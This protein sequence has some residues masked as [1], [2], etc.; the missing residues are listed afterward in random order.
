MHG[1]DQEG[2]RRRLQ[3]PV[4]EMGAEEKDAPSLFEG[5]LAMLQTFGFDQFPDVLLRE[6]GDVEEF[7][8]HDPHVPVNAPGDPEDLVVGFFRKGAPQV[9]NGDQP[10]PGRRGGRK[11]GRDR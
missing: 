8:R 1:F 10:L 6:T 9:V 2:R 5:P 11:A 4:A 3:L 7:R